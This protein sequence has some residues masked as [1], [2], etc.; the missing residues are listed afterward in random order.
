MTVVLYSPEFAA[1]YVPIRSLAGAAYFA[2][3]GCGKERTISNQRYSQYPALRRLT[4]LSGMRFVA[5]DN[6]RSLWAS[7]WHAPHQ[8]AIL[9]EAAAA[10]RY[11]A[12]EDQ[13]L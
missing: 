11:L 9:T 12:R 13:P 3:D 6:G 5:L 4:D 8:Y 1:D 7:L 2:V 10:Q